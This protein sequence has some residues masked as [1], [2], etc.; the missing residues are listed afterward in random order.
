MFSDSIPDDGDDDTG[1]NDENEEEI[2]TYR[3]GEQR[4]KVRCFE[5]LHASRATQ[6]ACRS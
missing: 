5:L 1:V 4:L 2:E 6:R 3:E